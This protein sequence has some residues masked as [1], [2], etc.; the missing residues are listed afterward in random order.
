MGKRENFTAGRV[1]A[2]EFQP[3]GAGKSTIANLVEKKLH[4]LGKHTVLLDRVGKRLK[5]YWVKFAARLERVW[6]DLVRLYPKNG[7]LIKV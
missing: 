1:A 2:Y 7:V 4:S 6:L 5:R 3:S